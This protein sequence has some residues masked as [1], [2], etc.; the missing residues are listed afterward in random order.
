MRQLRPVEIDPRSIDPPDPVDPDR[1]PTAT[2]EQ[3]AA[4]AADLAVS[5]REAKRKEIQSLIMKYAALDSVPVTP[6]AAGEGGA[7]VQNDVTTKL[8][9]QPQQPQLQPIST[10]ELIA[11]KYHRGA[12]LTATVSCLP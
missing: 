6:A 3:V 4:N 2:I 9:Q 11:S 8:R 10:T 1:T 7:T 12:N 5:E